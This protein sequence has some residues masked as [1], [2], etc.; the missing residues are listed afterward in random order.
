MLGSTRAEDDLLFP[1]FAASR[2]TTNTA[3]SN[4][5]LRSS[6]F[7][8]CCRKDEKKTSERIEQYDRASDSDDGIV[9]LNV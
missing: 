8:R 6:R 9:A 5:W 2:R 7:S 1:S 4:G 3:S